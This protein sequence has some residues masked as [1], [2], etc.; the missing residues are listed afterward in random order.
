LAKSQLKL[1]L[2][3]SRLARLGDA[4]VNF[5]FSLGRSRALQEPQGIKVSDKILAEALKKSG[6]RQELPNRTTR[7]DCANA[8][9]A[10]LVYGYLNKLVTIEEVVDH[11]A[12]TSDSPI[13]AF[14]ELIK[15]VAKKIEDG[16]SNPV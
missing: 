7:Q 4:Y 9:E 8:V 13:E 10:L 2:S 3:D 15:S 14:A 5:V 11:M 16:K 1:I 6:L 12:S